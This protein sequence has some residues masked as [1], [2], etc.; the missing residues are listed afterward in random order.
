M[1]RLLLGGSWAVI[2]RVISP[3]AQV[4][5]IVILLI[6]VISRVISP[7]IWVITIVILLIT[8]R[9]ANKRELLQR[10]SEAP[11]PEPDWNPGAKKVWPVC[12]ITLRVQVP[13]QGLGFRVQGFRVQG[14]GFTI[15][16]YFK[17]SNLHNCYPKPEH[18]I[19]GSFGPLGYWVGDCLVRAEVWGHAFILWSPE[20]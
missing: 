11:E 8:A 18:L 2:S 10:L 5:T 17:N 19:I 4:I 15:I 13:N 6:T 12:P 16:T 1:S 14:L 7:L 20:L 9:I 3:L